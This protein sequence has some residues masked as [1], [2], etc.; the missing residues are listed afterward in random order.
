MRELEFLP[1]W[2][3]VMRRRRALAVT[4][5]W[6]TAVLLAGACLW[7]ISGHQRVMAY[8]AESERIGAEFKQV[9]ADLKLLDEQLRMK[10]QLEQQDEILRRVGLQVD[11]T[12][13]LAE[14]DQLMSKQMFLVQ[15]S[16]ETQET[17]R[18]PDA[19]ATLAVVEGTESASK[20]VERP[21]RL[22]KVRLVGVAA[23]DVDIANFLAGLTSRAYLDRVAMTY[24]RDRVSQGRVMREFET[25]F[26]IDLNCP[27]ED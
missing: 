20:K 24:A 19:K 2:Y 11:F 26:V 17:I 8:Q 23:T 12:R 10:Q 9:R 27:E 7:G 5:S 14:I 15:I 4:Q 18:K 25:T 22:L 6:A 21:D 1:E 16:A 13:L 3:P